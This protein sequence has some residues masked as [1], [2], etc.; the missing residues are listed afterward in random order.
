MVKVGETERHQRGSITVF[1]IF[2]SFIRLSANNRIEY[3]VMANTNFPVFANMNKGP[4]DP[5]I[6][7][8]VDGGSVP[9]ICV[10]LGGFQAEKPIYR[11]K[12]Q[13]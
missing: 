8:F 12:I 1:G 5:I 6:R 2:Y 10:V 4:L 7:I 13:K 11:L 3:R 9:I